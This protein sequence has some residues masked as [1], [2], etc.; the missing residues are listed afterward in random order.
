MS[1][2]S[3]CYVHFVFF[4]L[5][6]FSFTTKEFPDAQVHIRKINITRFST[7]SWSLAYVFHGLEKYTT[8][9]NEVTPPK[10]IGTWRRYRRILN[11]ITPDKGSDNYL[12]TNRHDIANIVQLKQNTQ[13]R[14]VCI[15]VIAVPA[16][17]EFQ[18]SMQLARKYKDISRLH[19][20]R[21]WTSYILCW[22]HRRQGLL[23]SS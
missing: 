1:Q 8:V 17:K 22:P 10:V 13:M 5:D 18:G 2:F 6:T 16:E 20:N 3:F 19:R 9:L 4:T 21:K 23:S 12:V 11:N 14:M 15:H 7:D